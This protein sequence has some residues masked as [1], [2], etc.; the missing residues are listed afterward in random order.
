MRRVLYMACWSA[1]RTQACFKQRYQQLRARG[2]PAKVAITACMRVLLVRLNAMVRDGTP[3]R[4][5]AG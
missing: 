4:E 5:V 2:K 1:V 3:W